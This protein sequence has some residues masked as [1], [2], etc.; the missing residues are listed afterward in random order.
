MIQALA[1]RTASFFALGLVAFATEPTPSPKI[2]TFSKTLMGAE[3]L[4][5][6]NA[7]DNKALEGAVQS[8]YQEGERLNMIFSDYEAKSEVSQL[9]QSSASGKQFI[10]SPELFEL[11]QYAQNLSKLSDGAFD[12]T[13]GPLSRL[14]RIARFQKKLPAP[15][16]IN[17]ALNRVGYQNLLLNQANRSATAQLPGMVIDLGAIAKG[18]IADRMLEK[19][20]KGGYPRCLIDAGGDLTIGDAPKDRKGWR[21][22]IGGRRHPQLPVLHL[23]N[24][25]VA[26][27][28][29]MEQFLEIEGK[30]YS[31]ILNPLT[32]IGLPGGT[33][34][35][36]IA[37]N[38]M[39][40]D[41]LASMCL[42]L[43]FQKSIP[44]LPQT[45][46]DQAH[47]LV[48]TDAVSQYFNYSQ[49]SI[50]QE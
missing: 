19:M 3:V 24:C 30:R 34:A 43:G 29:D 38:C 5:L 7:E 16:K 46:A 28:G 32:G 39:I 21:V 6:V 50:T 1:I 20:K 26:T 45:R 17:H 23:A 15:N 37:P 12:V 4:I 35:T 22:E 40:A 9:S 11:L 8:T 44:L 48:T 13:I 31:H 2:I 25:A 27:S 42:V 49:D 33:Q 47:F 18:Y 10:I 36:V 14:W 41:S